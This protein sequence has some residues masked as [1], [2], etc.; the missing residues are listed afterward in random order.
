MLEVKPA[1]RGDRT[2]LQHW[3][4]AFAAG[5][6]ALWPV[7]QDAGDPITADEILAHVEYLASDELE[8]RN[9]GY[10]GAELAADVVETAVTDGPKQAMNRHHG[11]S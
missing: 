4:L 8:G 7:A 3:I 2:V 10:P 9:A 1:T 5:P 11:R 6:L